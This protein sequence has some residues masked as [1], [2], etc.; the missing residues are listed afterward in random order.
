MALD[1]ATRQM[2]ERTTTP[3]KPLK[4][5]SIAEVRAACRDMHAELMGPAPAMGRV[6]TQKLAVAGGEIS[7]RV[8]TPVQ[9]PRGVIVYYHGSGWVMSSIDEYETIGRKLA[10]RTSCAVVLAGYRLAPEHPYPAAPDDAYAALEW[11]AARL[12]E[13]VGDPD[14]PLMVAGDSAGGNLAAVTAIRAR[15]RGGPAIALQVLVYPVTDA[16]LNRPSYV[17]PDN[18]VMLSR[19]DMAWCWDHY[20]PDVARRSETD[21]SPLQCAD[22]SGLPPASVLT[23]EHDVLR[24]EGEA[25]AERLKGA[26]VDVDF[27]RHEGQLHGFF[28]FLVLPGSEGGF[29]QVVKAIRACWISHAKRRRGGREA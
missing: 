12:G 29:Q 21:A 19:D 25:Y 16:D 17:D 20:C 28:S 27:K 18:Q 15:D 26:G 1:F 14:A 6:E 3:W 24:D 13:I 11:S 5:S 10:E 7:L 9:P 23:A 22:L 8:L 2:L 4:E